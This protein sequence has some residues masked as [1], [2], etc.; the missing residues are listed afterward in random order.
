M[1]N[2]FVSTKRKQGMFLNQESGPRMY[3]TT[4]YR[5]Q[6]PSAATRADS[7]TFMGEIKTLV[8]EAYQPHVVIDLSAVSELTADGIDLLL[9]C[10]E[11]VEQADGS[12]SISSASPE[13]QIILELTRLTS[14][15]KT[16]DSEV[17][18]VAP[19]F[20][21]SVTGDSTGTGQVAA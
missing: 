9:E 16:I 17:E 1:I 2:G 5:L 15:V 21:S 19:E 10:V 8:G 20:I 13:V 4:M 11:R 12:V 3:T 18:L 7:R 6:F 14:V